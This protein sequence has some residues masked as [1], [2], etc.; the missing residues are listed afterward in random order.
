MNDVLI[1]LYIILFFGGFG[2][3]LFIGI[4]IQVFRTNRDPLL[5]PLMRSNIVGISYDVDQNTIDLVPLEHVARG[6]YFS[7]DTKNPMI[8]MK[9]EDVVTVPMSR[10]RK[11]A[12]LLVSKKP[13]GMA[14]SPE[15]LA[16]IGIV[17]IS[18]G[19][20]VKEKFSNREL[21]HRAYIELI[22]ELLKLSKDYV[23]EIKVS[24]DLKLGISFNIPEVV[25]AMMSILVSLSL[26]SIEGL[27]DNLLSARAFL[28]YMKYRIAG[29]REGWSKYLVWILII[30]IGVAIVYVIIQQMGGPR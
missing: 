15:T 4:L 3:G 19:K 25:K 28:E 13:H 8:V 14:V 12:L 22:S 1:V 17:S 16:K 9:P 18:L 7:M 10:M 27:K 11:N 2:F 26:A 6:V 5:G 21:S 29:A 23:G 30:C 24:Q 20:D